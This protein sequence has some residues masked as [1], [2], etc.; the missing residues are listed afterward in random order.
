MLVSHSCISS[1][2]GALW[3]HRLQV[4][5]PGSWFHTIRHLARG[6]AV[7]SI[8]KCSAIT[9]GKSCTQWRSRPKN[10]L[11]SLSLA[12]VFVVTVVSIA[13]ACMYFLYMSA[14]SKVR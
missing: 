12:A 1:M 14:L 3:P 7:S 6:D 5:L 9:L 4:H 8:S 2:T 10:L 13:G 11:P